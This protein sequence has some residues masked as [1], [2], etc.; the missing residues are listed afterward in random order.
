M[1]FL[2]KDIV[3]DFSLYNLLWYFLIYAF[4]GWCMEVCYAAFKTKSFINRGFLNGTYCP[5][6]GAGAC[7]VLVLLEPVSNHPFLVFLLSSLITTAIEFLTGLILELL[8][9]KKWWDYSGRRFNIKGYVCLEFSIIWGI[10]CLLVYD[11]LHPIVRWPVNHIPH[12]VG[13]WLLAIWLLDFVL[14]VVVSTVQATRFAK[15]VTKI[16]EREKKGSD[17]IGEKL[18]GATIKLMDSASEAKEKYAIKRSSKRL[19]KAFPTMKDKRDK[20]IIDTLREKAL[21]KK[22]KR[23]IEKYNELKEEKDA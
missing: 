22:Q 18:A 19:L 3:Y 13:I 7:V 23:A 9:H 20:S 5:L 10:C 6:Y 17:T 12:N 16:T 11:L 4:L 21:L 1:D 2:Y 15:Y 8:Y 14:D